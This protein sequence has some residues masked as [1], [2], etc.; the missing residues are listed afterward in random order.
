MEWKPRIEQKPG[1][2]H[3]HWALVSRYVGMCAEG[4]FPET[5]LL[6]LRQCSMEQS[7]IKQGWSPH[8]WTLL[9]QEVN[10]PAD[11]DAV[12]EQVDF[13][14]LDADGLVEALRHEQP[15]Q[16]PQVGGVVQG[17]AHPGGEALQQRQQHGP[18]VDLPCTVEKRH[19]Q[20]SGRGGTL[21]AEEDLVGGGGAH[22]PRDPRV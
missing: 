16:P 1:S 8:G 9:L 11:D 17:H 19:H 6:W 22:G 13:D 4:H 12:V 15:Q 20:D 5:P 7:E 18:G 2:E 14:V 10:A 3:T 21:C